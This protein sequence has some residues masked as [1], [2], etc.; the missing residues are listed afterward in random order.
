MSK[1]IFEHFRIHPLKLSDICDC[2]MSQ[3]EF[4][5]LYREYTERGPT[6]YLF[7]ILYQYGFLKPAMVWIKQYN[8]DGDIIYIQIDIELLLKEHSELKEVIP[9][10]LKN[11]D[12]IKKWNEICDF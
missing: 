11:E 5:P 1:L 6:E 7:R 2:C 4:Q 12:S 8:K 3:E 10:I 9:E